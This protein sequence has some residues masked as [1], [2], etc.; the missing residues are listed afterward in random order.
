MSTLARNKV[1]RTFWLVCEVVGGGDWISHGAFW[2][3]R[4]EGEQKLRWLRQWHPEA[5][6]VSAVMTQRDSEDT[7]P[8][9]PSRSARS[10]PQPE[11]EP[12]EKSRSILRLIP[13]SAPITTSPDNVS[14]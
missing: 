10:L 3:T 11:P 8:P 12:T 2:N 9:L 13:K 6:L 4:E 7:R 5:F 14:A 1:T